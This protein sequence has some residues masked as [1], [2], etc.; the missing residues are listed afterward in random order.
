MADSKLARPMTPQKFLETYSSAPQLIPL[1]RLGVGRLNR[2]GNPLN[3]GHVMTLMMRFHKGSE[4]GGEDFQT[5]RYQPA[6][7]YEP[8]PSNPHE[9]M[10]HTNEMA[11]RDPRIRPVSDE[12]T[13][14]LYSLFS[15]SHMWSAV[16]GTVGRSIRC[17]ND[18]QADILAPPADQPDFLYAEQHGLW[19]EVI[20]WDGVR[21]HPEVLAQVMRSE[22]FDANSALPEDEMTLLSDI[23][24]RLAAPGGMAKRQGEREFD[25]CLRHFQNLPG[26]TWSKRD[27]ECRYNLAKVIGKVHIQFLTHFVVVFVDFK[28]ITVSCA[29]LQALTRVPA[30]CPWVKVCLLVDNYMTLEPK[31]KVGGKGVADNWSAAT[32]QELV[33]VFEKE[34]LE[35]IEATVRNL[36]NLYSAEC[37]PT[38]SA[39]LLHKTQCRLAFR[40]GAIIRGRKRGE[41]RQQLAEVELKLRHKL[42][43]SDAVASGLD[44]K[45]VLAQEKAASSQQ[46]AA[47]SQQA[48][49]AVDEAPALQMNALGEVKQDIALLARAK[50][51]GVGSDCQVQRAARGIKRFRVGT[52]V[53]FNAHD[54][55]VAFDKHGEEEAVNTAF[56]LLSLGHFERPKPTKKPKGDSQP[57][58]GGS[59]PPIGKGIAWEAW[60]AQSVEASTVALLLAFNGQMQ[61]QKAPCLGDIRVLDDPRVLVAL[62]ALPPMSLKF[63]P[64]AV[65]LE[66]LAAKNPDP[67]DYDISLCLPGQEAV[68]YCRQTVPKTLGRMVKDALVIDAAEFAMASADKARAYG[69]GCVGLERVHTGTLEVPICAYLTQDPSFKPD[70]HNRTRLPV[71]IAYWTNQVEVPMGSAIFIA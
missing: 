8:D 24:K 66:R 51:F 7:V 25:A 70:K 5:Y 16:W 41:W 44:A 20:R 1:K 22:N 3:G 67:A 6:R 58:A 59:Q 50:G 21:D 48:A 34:E 36:M 63:V 2:G 69:G 29:C 26:Q 49:A 11:A 38:A 37:F 33:E 43:T 52:V 32:L 64:R 54:L 39:E 13:K 31:S 17:N 27:V 57:A 10:N 35:A 61:I 18:P 55:Q 23:H 56:P 9:C 60:D 53:G 4:G 71:C 40:L 47:S 68:Y 62:R 15:K 14:G 28:V 46:P 42:P 12:G 65:G 30:S 19:C 45:Y